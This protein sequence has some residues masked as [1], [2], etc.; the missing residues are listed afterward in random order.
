MSYGTL[1]TTFR[2]LREQDWVSVRDD[3]DEDGRIR[4]FKLTRGGQRVLDCARTDYEALSTFG[5][6]TQPERGPA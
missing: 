2:R 5:L 3:A 1:Y 4:F 6:G